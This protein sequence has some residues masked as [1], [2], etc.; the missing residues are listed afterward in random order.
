MLCKPELRSWATRDSL[1]RGRRAAV[2]PLQC[3]RSHT[4]RTHQT[5]RTSKR[6]K[7]RAPAAWKFVPYISTSEFGVNSDACRECE[8]AV[9]AAL[10]RRSTNRRGSFCSAVA[11]RGGDGAF[12]RT[13]RLQ[14]GDS[15]L[16]KGGVFHCWRPIQLSASGRGGARV[17]FEEEAAFVDGHRG[18]GGEGEGFESLAGVEVPCADAGAVE[19][20]GVG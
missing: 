2:T 3:P 12:E 4:V 6:R 14:N 17:A 5:V 11:Q 7:R 13:A 16:G 9:A 15:R 10:C 20:P 1:W 19:M 18:A 8:S